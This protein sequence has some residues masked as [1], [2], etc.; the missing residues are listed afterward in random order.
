MWIDLDPLALIIQFLN[1]FWIAGRL[2]CN[3]CEAMATSLS[4]ATSAVSSANVAVLDFGEVGTSAVYSRYNN[5]PLETAVGYTHIYWG[6]FCVL[7]FDLYEEV[8]KLKLNSM[9]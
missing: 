1:K 3:F 9:V 8:S 2:V 6:E 4:V 7:S 5:G